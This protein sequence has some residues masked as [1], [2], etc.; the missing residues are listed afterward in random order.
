[1]KLRNLTRDKLRSLASPSL[2][3]LL[4]TRHVTAKESVHAEPDAC[5]P[6]VPGANSQMK[7]VA[8]NARMTSNNPTQWDP[9]VRG[10]ETQAP[11]QAEKGTGTETEGNMHFFP[12]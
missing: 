4:V 1:M 7:M 9:W 5:G 2:E 12:Y 10:D 8:K 3:S 6:L 11:R